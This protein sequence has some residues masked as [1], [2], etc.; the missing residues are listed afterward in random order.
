MIVSFIIVMSFIIAIVCMVIL[1][2]IR[3]IK[4]IIWIIIYRCWL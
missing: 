3:K 4:F 2:I 1:M